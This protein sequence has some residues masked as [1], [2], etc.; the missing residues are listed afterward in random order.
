MTKEQLTNLAAL[1]ANQGTEWKFNPPGAPYFGSLWEVGVKALKYHIKRIIGKQ[2]LPYE[3]ILTL[4]VQIE[5]CLNSIPLYMMRGD[6]NDQEVLTPA[7]FLMTES[8]Y[9]VMPRKGRER[10]THQTARRAY[11]TRCSNNTPNPISSVPTEYIIGSL[12][13]VF[14]NCSVLHFPWEL[15]VAH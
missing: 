14:P 3:E 13:I 1:L 11:M 15:L 8:S 2:V 5:S 4:Q 9:L 6:T 12:E 10:L 7:H